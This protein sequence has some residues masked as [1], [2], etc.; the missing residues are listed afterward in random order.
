MRNALLVLLFAVVLVV[1]VVGENVYVG[2]GFDF[3]FAYWSDFVFGL[4]CW[5]CRCTF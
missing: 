3:V 4:M 5:F 2:R 1:L